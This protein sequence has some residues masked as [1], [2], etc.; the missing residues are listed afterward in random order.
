MSGRQSRETVAAAAIGDANA[1][2]GSVYGIA[3]AVRIGVEGHGD[4]A[5]TRLAG[6]LGQVAIAVDVVVDRSADAEGSD[7]GEVIARVDSLLGRIGGNYYR[8]DKTLGN[9]R[10]GDAGMNVAVGLYVSALVIES[11]LA[12][13]GR[14]RAGADTEAGLAVH[15]GRAVRAAD[16]AF[17]QQQTPEPIEARGVAHGLQRGGV[18]GGIG[19]EQGHFHATHAGD[20]AGI[21][22]AIAIGVEPGAVTHRRAPVVI[23]EVDVGVGVATGHRYGNALDLAVIVNRSIGAVRAQTVP[24]AFQHI[25]GV[26]DIDRVGARRQIIKA[27]IAGGGRHG[28]AHDATRGLL[29]Q[30]NRHAPQP[31]WRV[32]DEAVCIG[33]VPDSTGYRGLAGATARRITEILIQVDVA[34]GA[35]VGHHGLAITPRVIGIGAVAQIGAAI[36]QG[37]R[38]NLDHPSGEDVDM[39]ERVETVGVGLGGCHQRGAVR[40]IQVDGHTFQSLADVGLAVAIAI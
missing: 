40:Q 26:G 39:A 29:A 14:R 30:F 8:V 6:A 22:N 36:G 7:V 13:S 4:A 28:Q 31:L 38:V 34:G 37:G 33:I 20:L 18:T 35:D 16:E 5:D 1:D 19:D 27:I 21:L 23:T 10:R 9:G 32:D 2:L 25:S 12:I 24:P 17:I 11:H 3:V 15:A